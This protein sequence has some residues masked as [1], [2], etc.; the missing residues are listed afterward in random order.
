MGCCCDKIDHDLVDELLLSPFFVYDK[1]TLSLLSKKFKKVTY[2]AND[3]IW[4]KGDKNTSFN[5]IISGE[6]N[7]SF[8]S[9]NESKILIS[10][11]K[12]EFFGIECLVINDN[13]NKGSIKN[14]N[15]TNNDDDSG[16][17]YDAQALT[18]TIVYEL[19]RNELLNFWEINGDKYDI[20]KKSKINPLHKFITKIEVFR[21][22]SLK[23]SHVLSNMFQF[24]SINA[25]EILFNEGSNDNEFY[26][27]ADGLMAVMANMVP[28]NFT[29]TSD[30]GSD[31][32]P[33]MLVKKNQANMNKGYKQNITQFKR[34]QYF[35]E[36]SFL[37]SM[38]R[39]AT[40]K[41]I[42]NSILLVLKKQ[43]FD[44]IIPKTDEVRIELQ[45]I[46]HERI[47]QGFRRF[48]IPLF[49]A[50]PPTKYNLLSSFST[51]KTYKKGQVIVDSGTKEK[52]LYVIAHGQVGVFVT[53]ERKTENTP[54]ATPEASPTNNN[55]NINNNDSNN[56]NNNSNNNAPITPL[57]MLDQINNHEIKTN[58]N[59]SNDINGSSPSN[60]EDSG[61][62]T[63]ND[64]VKHKHR[65][66]LMKITVQ[67]LENGNIT[68]P[69]DVGYKRIEIKTNDKTKRISS[70]VLTG[71][72]TKL[73]KYGAI[74]FKHVPKKSNLERA[75]FHKE[76]I[77]LSFL[78]AEAS[79]SSTQNKP[80]KQL[81]ELRKQFGPIYKWANMELKEANE[82][83]TDD[84]D[85]DDDMDMDITDNKDAD[86]DGISGI[87][88]TNNNN[89]DI[90]NILKLDGSPSEHKRAV[91]EIYTTPTMKPLKNNEI[92][93]AMD[94][95]RK[96]SNESVNRRMSLPVTTQN[97][98]KNVT[99]ADLMILDDM[100]ERIRSKSSRRQS[101]VIYRDRKISESKEYEMDMKNAELELKS[102]HKVCC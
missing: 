75:V 22:L 85:D 96:I 3:I 63:Q 50:V 98:N 79:N 57:Q 9:D 83:E 59:E 16:V 19:T 76:L 100:T 44:Q 41:A 74:N 32:F 53:K 12:N 38:P 58:N 49:T 8:D 61:T 48:K 70:H 78:S 69:T 51:I 60:V 71:Q 29:T 21:T 64:Q 99:I 92:I 46:A 102:K 5:I 80:T 23:S 27:V 43:I 30:I 24:K 56:D 1:V 65:D 31:V 2:N 87:S 88:I 4:K 26:I 94:K 15:N 54:L 68:T 67:N 20:F 11:H 40:I 33:G 37:L 6:V 52:A 35:G 28:S 25:N 47:A 34:G 73:Q 93:E 10:K 90:T 91:S 84:D 13:K 82:D 101:E 36:I 14:K 95:T 7:L 42:Q 97:M 18:D 62:L 66:S 39:T 81:L 77:R 89:D 86:G 17:F 72:L 45:K 55:I